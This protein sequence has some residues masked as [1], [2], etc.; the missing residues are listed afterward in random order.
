MKFTSRLDVIYLAREDG[1]VILVEIDTDVSG[2]VNVFAP[3]GLLRGFV[4]T[5][6]AALDHAI[7]QSDVL[8]GGGDMSTGGLYVARA[9]GHPE[10]VE[11]VSNWTP[12]V[13]FIPVNI[14]GPPLVSDPEAG[15]KRDHPI[16]VRDRIFALTGRASEG[17]IS[18]MRRGLEARIGTILPYHGGVNRAWSLPD[19]A[20]TGTYLLIFF[21]THTE[22]LYVSADLE[23]IEQKDEDDCSGLD[24]ASTTLAAGGYGEVTVQVTQT[25]IHVARLGAPRPDDGSGACFQNRDPGES[26]F[27]ASLHP[28]S[29]SII[30]VTKR[31][32]ELF[33]NRLQLDDEDTCTI[34]ETGQAIALSSEPSCLH[35]FEFQNDLY[36]VVGTTDCTLQ[37]YRAN[38]GYGLVRLLEHSL[39]DE[40]PSS[41]FSI[42]ES[43]VYLECPPIGDDPSK[44]GRLVCGLRD[45]Y[46]K[47]Y[48]ISLC[49]SGEIS[50][51]SPQ[52]FLVGETSV[53]VIV[54]DAASDGAFVVCGPDCCRL[55]LEEGMIVGRSLQK[56]YLTDHNQPSFQQDN[57]STL[58]RIQSQPHLIESGFLGA[59]ACFS[60]DHMMLVDLEHNCKPVPRW[61]EVGG[62]PRKILHSAHLGIFVVAYSKR[63]LER[64]AQRRR[65]GVHGEFQGPDFTST[66]IPAL[67]FID[68]DK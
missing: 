68:P 56:I 14:S 58:V 28:S 20:G 34:I 43:A 7:N 66:F 48:A 55:Q 16:R 45:G 50:L 65:V 35:A 32:D 1:Q 51:H 8:V 13:D 64:V 29:S 47:S 41:P 5:A 18:E 33:M 24:L 57:I 21:P 31:A 44:L 46:I 3:T 11:T 27:A 62:T 67:R 23:S 10:L 49:D 30:T 52:V 42:C 37:F 54:D 25:S 22:L 38:S 6:F 39:T 19:C 4:N 36:I 40:P 59:V 9:R 15:M 63:R 12:L 26:I 53:E 60:K 2:W 61:L 17:S